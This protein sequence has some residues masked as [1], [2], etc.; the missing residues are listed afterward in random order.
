MGD[1]CVIIYKQARYVNGNHSNVF[2][3]EESGT[4]KPFPEGYGTDAKY[5]H[6]AVPAANGSDTN[7]FYNWADAGSFKSGDAF[8]I[9]ESTKELTAKLFGADEILLYAGNSG[10]T[11]QTG[12]KLVMNHS[13]YAYPNSS[14]P[15]ATQDETDM[16]TKLIIETEY[17]EGETSKTYYY[18]ISIPFMQPNYAYTI[19]TVTLHRLGSE[20]PFKPVSSSDC[21]FEITVRNWDTGDIVG[22]FNHETTGDDF[23]I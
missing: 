14:E 2:G 12:N 9:N 3:T 19:G 16:T 20:T 13:F 10:K 6:F 11:E 23:E 18:P 7:G 1:I 22:K 4:L 15:A 21:S 5:Y 17:T 8:P